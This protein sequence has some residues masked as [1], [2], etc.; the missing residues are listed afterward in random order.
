M[1]RGA[2]LVLSS[3]LL[4][5]NFK[6]TSPMAKRYIQYTDTSHYLRNIG[7]N[8]TRV[9]LSLC[10]PMFYKIS[11]SRFFINM[12]QIQNLFITLFSIWATESIIQTSV[13]RRLQVALSWAVVQSEVNSASTCRFNPLDGCW[14][15]GPDSAIIQGH[16][17]LGQWTPQISGIK[18]KKTKLRLFIPVYE[19]IC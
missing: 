7:N 8:V 3:S 2:I 1:I 18:G 17:I 11:G 14:P 10:V 15:I 16:L 6:E 5:P 19:E 4:S 12:S 13:V 9:M